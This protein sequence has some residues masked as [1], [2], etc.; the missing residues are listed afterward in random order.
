VESNHCQIYTA[1]KKE[2]ILLSSVLFVMLSVNSCENEHSLAGS[3]VSHSDCK[4]SKSAVKGE[5]TPDS[6][7]CVNYLYDAYT[8]KLTLNHINAAFN[9]CPGKLTC[10]ISM[11]GDTLIIREK[12]ATP[13]CNCDCL[14]DIEVEV[15]GLDVQSCFIRIIEP[16]SGNQPELFFEADLKNYPEGSYCVF[17]KQYPW[18]MGIY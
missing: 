5:E 4:S 8:K 13:M 9:C 15:E 11:S 16:S 14:F 2:I 17:R 12:E 7:S 3:I 6:L 10:R 1:M 18:G